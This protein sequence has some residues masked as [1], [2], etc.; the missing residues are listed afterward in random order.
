MMFSLK[1]G[2]TIIEL[3]LCITIIAIVS[4]IGITVMKEST[5]KAYE[6]YYFPAFAN[7]YDAIVEIEGNKIDYHT[8][9]VLAPNDLAAQ[10]NKHFNG[11]GSPDTINGARVETK[12]GVSFLITQVAGETSI[13]EIDIFVPAPKTRNTPNSFRRIVTYFLNDNKLLIPGAVVNNTF[14]VNLQNNR[15]WLAAYIE[16]GDGNIHFYTYHDAYC[17]K[18]NN[19]SI[20]LSDGTVILNCDG[21]TYPSWEPQDA[22]ERSVGV[23]RLV[24]PSKTSL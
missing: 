1:K 19:S 23:I 24:D 15:N 7:L 10:I 3:L 22:N 21:Y 13:Y 8:I 6:K 18:N 16:R 12:N 4:T 17:I 11:D 14:D 20:T 5:D 9:Q 2:F